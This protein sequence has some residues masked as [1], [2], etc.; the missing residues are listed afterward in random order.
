VEVEIHL[1][2]KLSST[3]DVGERSASRPDR[4][5]TEKRAPRTPG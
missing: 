2:L 3:Y 1:L 5:T 4:F